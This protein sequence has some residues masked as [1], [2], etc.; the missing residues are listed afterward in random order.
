MKPSAMCTG[1][2]E[3]APVSAGSGRGCQGRRKDDLGFNQKR[4]ATLTHFCT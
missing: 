2:E 4:A 3:G 1:A